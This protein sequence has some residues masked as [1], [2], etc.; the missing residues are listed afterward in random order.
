M[1]SEIDICNMALDQISATNISGFNGQTKQEIKCAQWYPV[2]RDALIQES[3]W[4]FAD[5][6]VTLT[7]VDNNFPS[8]NYL[9]SYLYPPDC[10]KIKSICA[11]NTNPDLVPWPVGSYDTEDTFGIVLGNNGIHN[12][13]R[14]ILDANGQPTGQKAILCD[15]PEAILIYVRQITDTSMFPPTFVEALA[16][17][18]A[19]RLAKVFNTDPSVKRDVDNDYQEATTQAKKASANESI[20]R[21]W[22]SGGY[23]RARQTGA[24]RYSA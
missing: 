24:R 3:F 7:P 15:L 11:P 19:R 1:P 22:D 16:L 2:E 21:D 17:R 20:D 12:V 5:T 18:L 13:I 9:F 6:E 8:L 4:T 14:V 23:I 10:L